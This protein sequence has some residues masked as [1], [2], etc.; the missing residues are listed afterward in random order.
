MNR[1]GGSRL[2]ESVRQA[3]RWDAVKLCYVDAGLCDRCAAQAAWGHQDN[4]TGWDGLRSP[5]AVCLPVV[6]GLPMPTT[7]LDWRRFERP[8][9]HARR[10]P[11]VQT[12]SK[13]VEASGSAHSAA[14]GK[15][16]S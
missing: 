10:K 1:A 8:Q 9:D 15:V 3:Q 6:S 7:N 2:P 4:A 13:A 14:K 12:A 16:A 5:C 11:G